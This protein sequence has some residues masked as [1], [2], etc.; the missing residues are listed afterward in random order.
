MK[1]S[2]KITS[3][4]PQSG[5]SMIEMLGVLAIIGV[6]SVGGIAGYS[7]AMMKYRIN[8][9]IEQISLISANIRTF[10]SNQKNYSGLYV[11]LMPVEESDNYYQLIKKAKILPDEMLVDCNN[12]KCV[13]N[14]FGGKV[15]IMDTPRKSSE[16]DPDAPFYTSFYIMYT[17]IPQEA[18]VE[19]ATLDWGNTAG[20]GLI[21]VSAGNTDMP[22]NESLQGCNGKVDTNVT[23]ACPN[24]STVSIP[25]PVDKAVNA[26]SGDDDNEIV[27][28]FY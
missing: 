24:G 13:E 11:S 10:F 16:L 6:L 23:I 26:C 14:I 3:R 18:C 15:E 9:T 19:L 12:K 25:M 28:K 4:Y 17:D 8:K 27:I 2:E 1:N 7:K 22:N 5:R 20:S 21:A